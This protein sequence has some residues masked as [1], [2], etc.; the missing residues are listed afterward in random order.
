VDLLRCGFIQRWQ[1]MAVGIQGQAN[2][3]HPGRAEATLK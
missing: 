3:D 1:N 2:F